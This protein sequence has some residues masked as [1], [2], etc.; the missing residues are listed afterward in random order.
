MLG[1]SGPSPLKECYKAKG[2]EQGAGREEKKC[3][4]L[5]VLSLA[6]AAVKKRA[7][8]YMEYKNLK[9]KTKVALISST[10]AVFGPME[11]AFAEIFPEAQLMH[12][13]DETLLEDFR[14]EGGLSLHSRAKALQMALTAQ[15]A[16][17]DGILFTCSTL[18][19]AVDDLRPFIS[20]PMVKI[21]E[22]VIS[23]LVQNF[24]NIGLLATAE[25]V[26]KSVENQFKEISARLGRQ[27]FW[28]SFV[29]SDT[30]P[31]LAKSP[32][33]FYRI[34]GE[35]ASALAPKHEALLLTQVSIAP[36]RNFAREEAKAKIFASP[37]FAV[38]TLKEILS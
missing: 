20:V 15:K 32:E 34:M 31:I 24:K 17:I 4:G 36:A 27:I 8:G 16:G 38:R 26:L 7:Q 5:R 1:R 14:R 29:K 11:D 19:P 2:R 30:W 18:S 22:P 9:K 12:I 3:C 35:Y 10:K 25:T 6:S 13:L 28:H 23:Y 37:S 33:E 21:D